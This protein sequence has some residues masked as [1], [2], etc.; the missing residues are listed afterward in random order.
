[1]R[2]H[3]SNLLGDFPRQLCD[4]LKYTHSEVDI[5]VNLPDKPPGSGSQALTFCQDGDW[6]VSRPTKPI[7]LPPNKCQ[8]L[9]VTERVQGLSQLVHAPACAV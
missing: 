9:P 6:L 3:W 2:Q 7:F 5:C 4:T 1:M 8:R